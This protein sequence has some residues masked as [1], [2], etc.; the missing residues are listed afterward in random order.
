MAR[1]RRQSPGKAHETS[2][3]SREATAPTIEQEFPNVAE[4]RI[5]VVFED[6]DQKKGPEPWSLRYA[7][8]QSAFFEHRCPYWEC[9]L[10]GFSFGSAVRAAV[11]SRN[12]SA[13]GT[14]TC[15]GWQDPERLYKHGCRL[16]AHYEI[17]IDYRPT[18]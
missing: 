15:P 14:E 5:R 3:M 17:E 13:T 1:K 6:F 10:G 16:K 12:T 4:I 8:K 9:V 11:S 2:R 7:P 18:L